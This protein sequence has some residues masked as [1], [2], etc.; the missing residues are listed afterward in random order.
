M[1][2]AL[3]LHDADNV[4]VC[5]TAVAAGETV[6]IMHPDGSRSRLAAACDITFT[7]KIALRDI[8]CGEDVLKYGESIGKAAQ[9]IARGALASHLNIAS[10]P[11]AYADEYILKGE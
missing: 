8:A 2:R 3:K 9:A 7:N 10:Q 5:T 4:A 11:R 6:E 1:A